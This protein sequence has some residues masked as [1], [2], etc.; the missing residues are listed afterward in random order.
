MPYNFKIVTIDLDGDLNT[1]DY[2]MNIKS[3]I[4]ASIASSII[5]TTAFAGALDESSDMAPKISDYG[6]YNP[7][8]TSLDSLTRALDGHKSPAVTRVDNMN[9]ASIDERD[10]DPSTPVDPAYEYG[11]GIWGN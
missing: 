1:E 5:S 4:F 8:K 11:Q 3:I 9:T 7:L 10:P 2:V 6:Q